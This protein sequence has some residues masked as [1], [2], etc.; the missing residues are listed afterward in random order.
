M[1]M[2]LAALPD[3]SALALIGPSLGERTGADY[4][5]SRVDPS[6][7]EVAR[8]SLSLEGDARSMLYGSVIVDKSAGLAIVN[9]GVRPKSQ[10]DGLNALGLPEFCVEGDTSDIAF[11]DVAELRETKRIRIDRFNATGALATDDGWLVIGDLRPG[12]RWET[13]AAVYRVKN[14]G[15]VDELWRDASPYWTSV[16]GIRRDGDAIEIVGRARRS[17]AIQEKRPAAAMPDFASM[18]SGNEGVLSEEV[19]S[20]RLSGNGTEERRDFVAAGFPIVPMGMASTPEHSVIFG[21]VGS[22]PLWLAR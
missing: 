18:R 19:F 21:T 16:D 20:V 8:L 2:G 14:D 5:V 12:C 13:R 3:Q 22:R 6:G 7:A 1:V 10:V 4:Y 11:L 17:V 15:S 9:R